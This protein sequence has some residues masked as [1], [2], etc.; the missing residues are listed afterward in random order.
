MLHSDHMRI[1]P[2]YREALAAS[3][4]DGVEHVLRRTTGRVAAWSR[5]TDTLYVAGARGAVGFYVKR[6]YYPG[7][8]KRLRGTLRGTFLGPHR[9]Q[10]EFR[11]LNEMRFLGLPAV[12]PVAH[13]CRRTGHFVTACFLI[14]EE[15]PGA[16][17]LTTFARDTLSGRRLLSADQRALIVRRFAQQIGELHAA[18]FA[19]GQLFW[20]NVLIR[21][22]PAGQPEFFFLDVRPRHGGRRIGRPRHW[23]IYE[24]GHLAASAL[25][26]TTRNE[27]MR[28]LVEYFGAR[29]L[30]PEVKRQIRD[31]DRLAQGWEHHERQRI[32]MNDLFEEWNRQ[33]EAENA[34]PSAVGEEAAGTPWR[35]PL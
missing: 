32:R 12:R 7:W 16:C 11:L 27:R 30:P 13:G 33:L 25:P 5:T 34:D 28:F 1:D 10:A 18:G 26:F 15:V 31:I 9:G 6:Y 3:E 23:W 35:A 29:Q 17:N 4:L 8:R 24:L 19:H 22:G 21:F 14:T 2:A 20:R